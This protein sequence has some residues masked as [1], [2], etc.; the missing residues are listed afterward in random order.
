VALKKQTTNIY[1]DPIY[2]IK[3][4]RGNDRNIK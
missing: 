1:D 2:E 4:E 3:Q